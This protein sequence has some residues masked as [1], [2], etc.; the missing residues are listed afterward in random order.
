VRQALGFF[1]AGVGILVATYLVQRAFIQHTPVYDRSLARNLV[2]DFQLNWDIHRKPAGFADHPERALHFFEIEFWFMVLAGALLRFG[3]D[4]V[5]PAARFLLTGLIASTICATAFTLATEFFLTSLP[6]ELRATM[7]TR[8]LNFN[9]AVFPVALLGVLGLL[10]FER[11]R[12]WALIVLLGSFAGLLLGLVDRKVLLRTDWLGRPDV[13]AFDLHGLLFPLLTLLLVAFVLRQRGARSM[14][15]RVAP[16]M[17]R[18]LSVAAGLVL[19]VAIVVKIGAG[20]IPDAYRGAQ[21]HHLRS[22]RGTEADER[23]LAIAR[24]RDGIMLWPNQL[25]AH[26]PQLR[27]RRASV[28]VPNLVDQVAYAPAAAVPLERALV[29]IY[30]TSM[31][32]PRGW[33]SFRR[34]RAVWERRSLRGWERIRERFAA[35]DVLVPRDWRVQ[36]PAVTKSETL[37]LYSIPRPRS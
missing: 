31:R 16:G 35:V 3:R 24:R 15:P 12:A 34:T 17:A 32:N 37:A 30:G 13:P 6:L 2:D 1:F 25:H 5:T 22:Q 19:L 18:Q 20:I 11:R 23:T 28:V 4:V 8:W 27:S 14:S 7:A 33:L 21:D 9:Y 26:W 36:L 29:G 10:A